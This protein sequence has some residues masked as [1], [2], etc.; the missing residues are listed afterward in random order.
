MSAISILDTGCVVDVSLDAAVL[1]VIVTGVVLQ[2][3]VSI[4]GS[5]VS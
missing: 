4:G 1:D 3:A 2:V 5:A